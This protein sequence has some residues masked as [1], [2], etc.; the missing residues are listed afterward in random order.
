M[1]TLD[2]HGQVIIV[3]MFAF[4]QHWV[5]YPKWNSGDYQAYWNDW[6]WTYTQGA[7][8]QTSVCADPQLCVEKQ[9][10]D[11]LSVHANSVNM[12]PFRSSSTL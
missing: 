11:M 9:R 2:V 5:L 3:V 10:F 8:Q 4:M 6:L 12:F 1:W 7:Q